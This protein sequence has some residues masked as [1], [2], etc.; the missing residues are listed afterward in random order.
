MSTS[1]CVGLDVSKTRL[2]LAVAGT[3]GT[4]AW[5]N[6][7]AGIAALVTAVQAL[8][9][10]L[11][12][13]EATG[14]YE[15]PVA[16]ALGLARLPV[17][18]VNPRQVR[19]FAR[20]LGRLAKTDA[21]DAG[22]LAEFAA[23]VRPEP[24]ALPDAAH[25]ALTALVTRRRQLVE[26]LTAERH[27]LPLAQGPVR[28]DITAHIEW[29]ERRVK[30][31]NADLQAALAASPLWRA[32]EQLL[33]SVPGI[34]PTT[35]AT[36]IADLPELGDLTRQ[37]LAALVGVAPFNHDS[38]A[39]RGVRITWGGRASVRAALYMATLVATR[40]NPAIRHFYQRLCAAGKPRKVALVAAMRKLLS[41]LNAIIKHNRAWSDAPA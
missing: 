9:P 12:V 27:R 17:A 22:V 30:N 11:V 8:A 5:S 34:G 24:R 36:L 19:D 33:R 40:H 14:G 32:T 25:A 39:Y 7:D 3:P 21:I 31:A 29:L 20:A 16:T 18:V 15:T 41:I 28:A 2:D 10:E 13:L 37:Q 26:M 23:R 38:G 6:D 4:R 1:V 35:A